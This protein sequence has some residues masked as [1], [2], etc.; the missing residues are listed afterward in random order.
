MMEEKHIHH[1]NRG[2]GVSNEGSYRRCRTGHTRHT[3]L[4]KGARPVGHVVGM[5]RGGYTTQKVRRV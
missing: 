1:P 2:K 5:E 4:C 3:V